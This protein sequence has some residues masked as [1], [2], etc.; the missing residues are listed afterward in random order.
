MPLSDH[1]TRNAILLKG[2][3]DGKT[4][5]HFVGDRATH[6]PSMKFFVGIWALGSLY[7]DLVIDDLSI[8]MVSVVLDGM[9]GARTALP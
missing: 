6:A 4:R 2:H 3:G 1:S 8:S 5:Q 9:R 7:W